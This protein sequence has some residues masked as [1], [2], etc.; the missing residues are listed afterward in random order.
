MLDEF[1]ELYLMRAVYEQG[2]RRDW[3]GC[4]WGKAHG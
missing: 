2:K 4:L 3:P 1:K